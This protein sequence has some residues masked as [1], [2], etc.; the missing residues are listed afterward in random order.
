MTFQ[1][2][3]VDVFMPE[4]HWET[5]LAWVVHHTHFGDHGDAIPT[6]TYMSIRGWVSWP[7]DDRVDGELKCE[8][9]TGDDRAKSEE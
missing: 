9:C 2:I 4:C 6:L 5:L 1:R 3:S 7:D 8:K